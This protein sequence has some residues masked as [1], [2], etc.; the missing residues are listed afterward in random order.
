[1]SDN[2]SESILKSVMVLT[3]VCLI[4]GVAL[5]G[6]YLITKDKIESQ[7]ELFFD[8]T[9]IEV[10]PGAEG[11]TVDNGG[12]IA[13]N[14]GETLGT[15]Q[16]ADAPGY[17]SI[18]KV[19]VGIDNEGKIVGVRILEQEETPGLGANA[20][21]PEF[22]NQFEGLIKDEVALKADGGKIDAITGAT[23]TTNAI[24]EGINKAYANTDGADTQ[25]LG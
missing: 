23:V 25:N 22:Y 6:V 8:S 4:S 16:I 17:A 14:N 21:K 20:L 19:A 10:F 15:I 18:V 5:G 13:M 3:I 1:M 9:L 2:N 24:I 12:Y 11:F 7:K